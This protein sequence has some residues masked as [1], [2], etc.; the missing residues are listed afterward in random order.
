MTRIGL[1]LAA[2]AS[3]RLGQPK[4]LLPCGDTPLLT[5]TVRT[6]RAAGLEPLVAFGDAIWEDAA[7]GAD[8]IEVPDPAAGMGATIAAAVLVLPPQIERCTIIPVDLPGLPAAHLR[9]L[10]A[11]PTPVGASRLPDGRLGAPASFAQICFGDLLTLD[12]DR[13]ARDLIRGGRW[14]VT[15]LAPPTPLTDIDTPA[16]WSRWQDTQETPCG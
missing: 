14:P 3:R 4:A 15:A 6:V 10:D 11:V 7:D 8:W 12:G 1:I 2:G 5:R 9:A 16:D 13:G